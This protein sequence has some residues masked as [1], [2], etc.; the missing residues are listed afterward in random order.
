[1]ENYEKKWGIMRKKVH[2]IISYVKRMVTYESCDVLPLAS[3]VPS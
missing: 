2:Y 3:M 1:M